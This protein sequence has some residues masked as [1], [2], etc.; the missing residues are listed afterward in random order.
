MALALD[1]RPRLA[2]KARLVRDRASGK[3]VLLYP[4]RGLALNA[5]AAAVTRRLDGG[6][7]VA[8]IAAQVARE[9]VEAPAGEVERDVLA[10][11]EGLRDRALIEIG[12]GPCPSLGPGPSPS[13]KTNDGDDHPYTLIAELTYRCPLR[14]PYCS[15]P[16]ELV[17]A[18][19]ELSTAE[20]TRVLAEAAALGVMQ[21]HLTGGE[22]LARR[23]LEELAAAARAAGLYV[24]LV[25]S[26]VPLAR[27]RL[28]ALR[29]AG[30]DHV[31]LSVQD[32][33]AA[34]ADRVAGYPA[35]AHK[36]E[37]AAW[38]KAEGL[39]LTVNVVLHRDNL[40]RI[41]AIVA[42]AEQLGADRLE[43]AN[44]QY[45]GWALPNRAALLPTREQLDRAFAVASEARRRLLGKMEMIY[46]TPDYYAAWPRACMEGWARRYVHVTPTGLVLPCHA[47]HTLPGL[48]FEGVRDRP[49]AAVWKDA[50][51]L[52]RFRGDGWMAEPCASCPR[53]GVD[54]GGCRCQAYHL[55]GDAAATD[56]ACSLSPAHGLVEAAR[57][58]ASS[59]RGVHD[60]GD[61]HTPG[62]AGRD[63][64][65]R[66]LYRG[67]P[68]A[69]LSA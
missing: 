6:R 35:F 48:V 59:P 18:A 57:L 17:S 32:A 47:A 66:Y 45:L 5:V 12:E 28:S 16:V 44:T 7:T 60:G 21:V 40:D 3:E 14:C 36:L 46:V 61:P 15:N 24:N 25:T 22:P 10:F 41:E 13:P 30:V 54:Y 34:G 27:A 33:D 42:F 62:P 51:G 55:A 50:P 8:E 69:P 23:D 4:E 37:V 56:P 63:E 65:P 1:D 38:V 19:A 67:P 2:N 20:W 31:Q 43:L 11:L 49:L 26:G 64:E 53:K 9:F 58:T 29:A 68:R 52:Q 39:P